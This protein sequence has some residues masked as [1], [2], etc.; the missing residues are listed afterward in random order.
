VT[1]AR[2]IAQ[3]TTI[4]KAATKAQKPFS[5][6]IDKLPAKAGVK[7]IAPLLAGQLKQARKGL[8]RLR[9]IGTPRT[10]RARLEAYY[11]SA[12]KLAAAQDKLATAAA[13]GDTATAR[14]I[15]TA[16]EPLFTVEQRLADK[17][18][19]TACDNMF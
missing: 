10:D 12:E 6:Q 16:N 9:A 13:A 14:R 2:Y 7:Q 15:S 4:C 17:F 11:A 5:D 8:A 18:G 19:I 1:K 3:A